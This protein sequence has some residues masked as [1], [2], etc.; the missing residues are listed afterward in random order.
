M[1]LASR[2]LAAAVLLLLAAE[3]V[4]ENFRSRSGSTRHSPT[5]SCGPPGGSS[6]MMNRIILI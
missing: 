1:R 4:A 6:V 3:G 2:A 5:V